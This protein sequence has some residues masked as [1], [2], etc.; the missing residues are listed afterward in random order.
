[1]SGI[2]IRHVA[3]MLFVIVALVIV[4][5]L[6]VAVPTADTTHPPAPLSTTNAARP[7]DGISEGVTAPQQFPVA[8]TS[9]HS[10]EAGHLFQLLG[11]IWHRMTVFLN[12]IWQVILLLGFG[13]L[14]GSLILLGRHLF[15]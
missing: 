10:V 15:T 3:V 9:V 8:G 11:P 5:L 7:T 12:P 2:P 4:A 6:P 1:M 13:S 14:L